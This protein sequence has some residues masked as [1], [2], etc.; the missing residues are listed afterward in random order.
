MKAIDNLTLRALQASMFACVVLVFTIA[1][2]YWALWEYRTAPSSACLDCNFLPDLV[3][4][5]FLPLTAMIVIH[6]IFIF[7]KPKR[8]MRTCVVAFALML[9]WYLIDIAIFD[10]R[11]ASWSTYTNI[12]VTGL[13]LCALQISVFGS[14][15]AVI[16]YKFLSCQNKII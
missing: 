2:G 1:Q 16:Y 6:V 5:S 11:E 14:V 4:S 10:E 15:K 12:W 9:C 13:Y 3:L 8:I 7:I